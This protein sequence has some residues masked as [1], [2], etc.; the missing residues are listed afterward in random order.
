MPSDEM[1]ERNGAFCLDAALEFLAK[2]GIRGTLTNF[3]ADESRWEPYTRTLNKALDAA[4]VALLEYNTPFFIASHASREERL[5]QLQKTLQLMMLAEGIGCL[6]VTVCISGPGG[7]SPHP[8][9]RNPKYRQNLKEF[10]LWLAERAAQAGLQARLLI[11][12]VYT[13]VMGSAEV[14]AAFL[15]EVN[16]PHVQAHLDVQNCLNFDVIYDLKPV[17]EKAFKVLGPWAKSA[18]IKDLA[19]IP[20]YMPGLEEKLVGD[21]VMDHRTHLRCLTKMPADFPVV[22]EHVSKAEDIVR[23]YRRI[24]AIADELGISVWSE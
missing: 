20:F 19:P 3:P 9:Q 17:I 4:G 24:V 7:L 14:L 18:H 15:A 8:D 23:S 12:P 21:G 22:I 10:C 5:E 11:E 2:E 16:S 1:T 6:N 13:T